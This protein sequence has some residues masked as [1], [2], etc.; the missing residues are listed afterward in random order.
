MKNVKFLIMLP[1]TVQEISISYCWSVNGSVISEPNDDRVARSL[2]LYSTDSNSAICMD[3]Q[4]PFESTLSS[5]SKF[6]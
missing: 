2:T 6:N 3:V 1:L 5:M 4:S